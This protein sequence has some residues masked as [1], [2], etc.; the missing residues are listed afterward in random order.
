MIKYF[1]TRHLG[2]HV[3]LSK[4]WRCTCLAFEMLKGY[5][6]I[7]RNAKGVHGQRKVGNLW[8]RATTNLT[9]SQQLKYIRKA[10]TA[11]PCILAYE[12][13]FNVQFTQIENVRSFRRQWKLLML[14]ASLN[15]YHYMKLLND[16]A[17]LMQI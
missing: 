17:R 6:L 9:Y 11:L 16:G 10:K 3:H 2:V 5:M 13:S 1:F 15:F 8:I 12:P 4:Y 7:C 14:F